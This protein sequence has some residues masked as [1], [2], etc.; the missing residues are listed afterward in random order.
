MVHE[1]N[2]TT[3]LGCGLV[4]LKTGHACTMFRTS[5]VQNISHFPTQLLHMHIVVSEP[6]LTIMKPWLTYPCLHLRWSHGPPWTLD[7]SPGRLRWSTT[8]WAARAQVTW[9]TP[10]S[11]ASQTPRWRCPRTT[12]AARGSAWTWCLGAKWCSIHG[13]PLVGHICCFKMVN[14][15]N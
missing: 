9:T 4:H 7:P 6:T 14:I 10:W 3:M 5:H 2:F 12:G 8:T 1:L 13:G 15:L 11:F